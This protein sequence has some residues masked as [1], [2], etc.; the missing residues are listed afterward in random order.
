MNTLQLANGKPMPE[1]GLGTWKSKP[2]EVRAAVREAI[3]VGYRH[4]DGASAYDN[5]TEVG[6]GIRDAMA[7]GV[8]RD[9]LW[10]TSKLWNSFHAPEDVRPALEATLR[11]LG[12]DHL[13]LYLMHWPVA[14]HKSARFPPQA[15]DFIP[16][17]ELPFMAT[18]HAMETCVAAGLTRHIG[19]SNFSA[20]K[21][22]RVLAEGRI[23]PA[24]NQV[25]LHPYL[26]QP[27]LLAYCTQNGIHVTAYSPLGSRDRP[28]GL[29]GAGE[30]VLLDDPAIRAIA[31]R[32]GASPAQVLIAWALRRGTAVIPKSVNAGRIRENFQ[33]AQ[34][35]LDDADM[36]S[37]AGLDRH[38]RYL[39]GSLWTVPGGGYTLAGLWDE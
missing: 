29:K 1:L 5:E 19:V 31:E 38:R 12:L 8:G 4:I 14:L 24:M 35:A 28:H 22:A 11:D 30:P 27:E 23:K 33:A 6:A 13:D 16:P 7:D 26:Q 36:A 3:R 39:D 15:D 21:L 10:V 2:G 17:E 37:I 32:A 9:E 20:H 34:L 25:E 18:W